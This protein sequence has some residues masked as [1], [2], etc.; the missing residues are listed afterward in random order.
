MLDVFGPLSKW[1]DFVAQNLLIEATSIVSESLSFARDG[2]G[3]R[4]ETCMEADDGRGCA[5][6]N[7][8]FFSS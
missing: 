3:K 4:T 1:R 2:G 8:C 5:D 7:D 6:R